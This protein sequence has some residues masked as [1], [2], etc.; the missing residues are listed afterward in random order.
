M[1]SVT[2]TSYNH[3]VSTLIENSAG[4]ILANPSN[5]L[6]AKKNNFTAS[7]GKK[8]AAEFSSV[9]FGLIKEAISAFMM[10]YP[11]RTHWERQE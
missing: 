2:P 5:H 3:I 7:K 6:G 11:S 10:D 1:I 4:M 8:A 9:D